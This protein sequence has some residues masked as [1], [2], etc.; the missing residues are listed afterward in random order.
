MNKQTFSFPAQGGIIPNIPNPE[1]PS[2]E[3]HAGQEV[4]VDLD[5]M[6]VIET[7]LINAPAQDISIDEQPTQQLAS[8]EAKTSKKS[9]KEAKD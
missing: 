1:N 5:T 8:I 7:R 6:T 3:F 4:D 9:A 2:G